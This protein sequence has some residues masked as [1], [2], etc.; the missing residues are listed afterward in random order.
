MTFTS[1]LQLRQELEGVASRLR[2]ISEAH[3]TVQNDIALTR[4]ATEKTQTD[5]TK[6]QEEKLNQVRVF[7]ILHMYAHFGFVLYFTP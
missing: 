2:F 1:A 5:I 4:R 7:L 6:A 3:Q